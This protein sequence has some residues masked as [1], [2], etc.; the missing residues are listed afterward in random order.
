MYNCR[1]RR[2]RQQREQHTKLPDDVKTE[3]IDIS[4]SA[5]DLKRVR[6]EK[7]PAEGPTAAAAATASA[8]SAVGE[9]EVPEEEVSVFVSLPAEHAA[10]AAG[11]ATTP[12]PLQDINE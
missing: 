7:Q 3:E 5:S 9:R 4:G 12:S 6:F 8:D 1:C 10:S 2:H 11:D